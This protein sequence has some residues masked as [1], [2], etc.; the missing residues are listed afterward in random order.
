MKG[1][2]FCRFALGTALL[3]VGL[4]CAPKSAPAPSPASP[5]P[6]ATSPAPATAAAALSAEDVA[7]ANVVAQAKKEGKV[8]V[9]TW[10]FTGEMGRA[11]FNAF[12]ERYGIKVE[13]VTGQGATLIERIKSEA[14]AKKYIADTLDT[15]PTAVLTARDMGL[16]AKGTEDLPVLGQKGVWRT[17]PR[18]DPEG[19]ILSIGMGF[20]TPFINTNRIKP[21]EEPKS[22]RDLLDP[23]WKGHKIGIYHPT[24]VPATLN[25]VYNF[26][27]KYGV[28]EDFFR[29]LARQEPRVSPVLREPNFWLVNGEVAML[30]M[31]SDAQMGPFVKE[32]APVKPIEF[33]GGAIVY[34]VPGI[35]MVKNAP[36]PNATRVYLNWLL[37]PEGQNTYLKARAGT[38]IRNDVPDFGA[39]AF[40][41]KASKIIVDTYGAALNTSRIQREMVVAKLMGI[42]K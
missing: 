26:R 22:F 40:R 1:K 17:D 39:E 35:A 15:S 7:W 19:H 20:Q 5:A 33:E 3:I 29:Q 41:F 16:T 21:G 2:W 24:T 25:Y 30:A 6:Q 12:E 23:K 9:Y 36:H 34:S 10:A 28:D 38:P 31:S 4:A 32:G 42:E 13:A 37:S 11:V 8:T 18:F 14:A 27:D